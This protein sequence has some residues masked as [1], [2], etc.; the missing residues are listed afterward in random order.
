MRQWVRSA[1]GVWLRAILP[2]GV[3][4][5]LIA[6]QASSAQELFSP[7]PTP[8]ADIPLLDVDPSSLPLLPPGAGDGLQAPGVSDGLTRGLPPAAAPFAP[9]DT[10]Q[11]IESL[12]LAPV[13]GTELL[14]SAKLV[15]GGAP[16][17]RGIVWRLFGNEPGPD[18]ELPLVAE[19][20]GGSASF[21]VKPGVYFLH[22]SFGHAG[23]TER[24]EVTSGLVQKDVVLNA[25]GLLLTATAGNERAL[26]HDQVW[27]DIYS[28][29]IDERGERTKVAADVPAGDIVRLPAGTY[30][31]VSRYGQVN[32]Q[33]RAD[34]EVKAGKLSEVMLTQ[35]AAEVT[36]KLV[37]SPGGEAIADT[38][39]SILT[40]GGD[41]VAEGVGAFPSFVL[42]AG[43]Y[44]VIA[45]HDDTV[46]QREFEV[47]SG[48][49]S[50]VE[51]LT[52]SDLA[53]AD[54]SR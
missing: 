48:V 29:E 19:A 23:T 50:E 24:V 44:T 31:V 11:G 17:K 22:C 26:P 32:A 1:S 18:G 7:G 14:A 27:F 34:L 33:T 21:R 43:G 49:D 15:D 37:G 12:D 13:V 35:R 2:A 40:P 25:G 16:I 41:E 20:L 36:L 3:A 42:A 53:A 54:A 8:P 46:F 45:K 39:W 9:S 51:V 52:T 5:Y 47:E 38:R 10:L 28:L 4:L 6:G 30:H